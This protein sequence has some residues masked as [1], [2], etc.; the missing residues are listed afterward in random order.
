M[1][2]FIIYLILIVYFTLLSPQLHGQEEQNSD[3]TAKNEVLYTLP[4]ETS[5]HEGTWLQWPHHYQY[6]IKYRK[7]LDQT[8]IDIAKAL[9]TS[10]NV[11]LIAYNAKEKKELKTF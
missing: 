9:S 7:E 1:K 8:W 3:T 2:T 10:E 6:G 11:H 4:A 5:L